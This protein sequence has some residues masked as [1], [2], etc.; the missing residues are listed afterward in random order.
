MLCVAVADDGGEDQE[1]ELSVSGSSGERVDNI[2]QWPLLDPVQHVLKYLGPRELCALS[3]VNREWNRVA[4]ADNLWLRF[5]KIMGLDGE[6]DQEAT[7]LIADQAAMC[8]TTSN[9]DDDRQPTT[10]TCSTTATINT[11]STAVDTR[12]QST[13][14][15]SW[16]HIVLHSSW[17]RVGE[18]LSVQNTFGTAQVSVGAMSVVELSDVSH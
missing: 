9:G 4:N 6:D 14:R 5:A 7:R 15:V 18:V 13:L 3:C 10:T 12:S 8:C 16:K 1:L 17:P 11:A 2:M